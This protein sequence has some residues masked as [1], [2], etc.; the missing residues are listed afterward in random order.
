MC[1]FR[2]GHRHRPSVPCLGQ[3]VPFFPVVAEPVFPPLPDPEP[4]GNPVAAEPAVPP[5][6]AA[7]PGEENEVIAS[8]LPCVL[9]PVFRFP[10]RRFRPPGLCFRS[11]ALFFTLLLRVVFVVVLILVSG[12]FFS[13]VCAAFHLGWFSRYAYIVRACFWAR[14]CCPRFLLPSHISLAPFH[15]CIVPDV[16]MPL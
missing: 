1:S 7:E 14:V 9:R 4:A 13:L 12:T 10:C 2:R 11:F 15:N 5:A 6:E 8:L 16:G 3:P